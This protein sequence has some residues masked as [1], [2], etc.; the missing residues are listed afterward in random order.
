MNTEI[1][2]KHNIMNL[3]NDRNETE[4]RKKYFLYIFS[5]HN[6]DDLNTT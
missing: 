2:T 4:S 6:M 1:N 3:L 5:L